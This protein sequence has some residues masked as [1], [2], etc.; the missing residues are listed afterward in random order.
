MRDEIYR[1]LT[2]LLPAPVLAAGL[3]ELL[4]GRLITG[5]V[6][7]GIGLAFTIVAVC[8]TR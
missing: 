1:L 6:F 8:S 4:A 3:I 2:M 5:L 7:G